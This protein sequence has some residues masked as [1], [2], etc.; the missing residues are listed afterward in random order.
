MAYQRNP[1]AP[2]DWS[3]SGYGKKRKRGPTDFPAQTQTSA[4]MNDT[5]GDNVGVR[6]TQSANWTLTNKNNQA[7]GLRQNHLCVLIYILHR[8]ILE[9]RFEQAGRAWA[10]LLRMEVGGHHF[11]LR[12]GERWG[13]GA[14][15]IFR[16]STKLTGRSYSIPSDGNFVGVS[17]GDESQTTF[18]PAD[19]DKAREYYERLILQYPYRRAFPQ[20]ISSIDIYPAMFGLWI[21]SIDEKHSRA[22]QELQ[23]LA[24]TTGRE[25]IDISRKQALLNNIES[26][27][28]HPNSSQRKRL[29]QRTLE[30]VYEVSDR[31]NDLTSSPPFS[32]NTWFWSLKHMIAMWIADLLR[33]AG[34]IPLKTVGKKHFEDMTPSDWSQLASDREPLQRYMHRRPEDID[35]A[36]LVAKHASD[37]ATATSKRNQPVALEI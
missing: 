1:V 19:C 26:E 37:V 21:H 22:L 5:V 34:H 3:S 35:S 15:L 9:C 27:Q 10:L 12:S 20:A 33:L 31:L 24:V 29:C 2:Q 36:L 14:E 8:S 11:D 30:R 18:N 32:D 28:T 25:A 17:G 7:H 23:D 16:R 6:S 4:M 13:F